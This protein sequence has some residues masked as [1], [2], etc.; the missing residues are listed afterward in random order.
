MRQVLKIAGVGC[1]TVLVAGAVLIAVNWDRITFVARNLGAM[2]D[3]VEDAQALRSVDALLDFIDADRS[4]V[5]L[6]AYRL[7]DPDSAILLNP[8]VPRPLAS[9][10]KIL[11]LAGYA[12]AVDDGRWSPDERVP[13]ADVEAFFLPGTDG[14]VHDRAVEVYLERG[15]LDA[16]DTVSLRDVVWAMMTVSDNAATDYLL[17]R[18]GRDAAE[19]LPAR[20]GLD[21]SD[22]PLPISGVFLSWAEMVDE[23]LAD[24]A[25]L[26][27]DRLRR[28]PEFRTTRQDNPVTSEVSVREQARLSV[29]RF[30]RGTA[31]DYAALMARVERG[32][33][34][35]DAASATMREFL[36][37]PMENEP[38]RREFASYG[39]KGGSLAGVLTEASYALPRDAGSGAVAAVFF[40]ELPFAVWLTLIQGR[41]RQDVAST[42]DGRMRVTA[43]VGVQGPSIL[44]QELLWRL[45]T[46]PEFFES[47]RRR[48][49]AP[50]V[51]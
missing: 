4:R 13:L 38:V 25:W 21:G 49:E 7:D 51:G 8:D 29:A 6:V 24:A 44:H 26:L 1:L 15:W 43:E 46:D 22:A 30:P 31:R 34:V 14:G 5:S 28:E 47:V 50:A 48:L 16:S 18:L 3:G 10:I 27:A 37:W 23:P 35:S 33:L 20:L 42:E 32:N 17:H 2:F 45:L 9:T 12:E 11:V 39:T 19:A 40:E 36:E 41:V